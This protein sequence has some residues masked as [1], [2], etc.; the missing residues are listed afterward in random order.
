[1][2]RNFIFFYFL[3]FLL[4]SCNEKVNINAPYKDIYVVY[5]VLNPY[6]SAQY[7]RISKVFQTEEDAF[8]TAAENDFSLKGLKVI[9]TG[10]GKT[11]EA[12][13]EDSMPKTPQNGTFY[14]Y[15]TVY[16]LSANYLNGLVVG[17]R[18][19]LR[20]TDPQNADFQ[21]N[22]HTSIPQV[23]YLLSPRISNN[24]LTGD[25]CIAR[26]AFEDT[27]EIVFEGNPFY[28]ACPGKRYEVSLLWNYTEK[29]QPKQYSWRYSSLIEGSGEDQKGRAKIMPKSA[30]SPFFNQF[31]DTTKKYQ[32]VNEPSCAQSILELPTSLEIFITSLDTTL[33][34]Y[35]M[36]NDP[37]YP[38]FNTYRPEYTNIRGTKDAVGIFGSVSVAKSPVLLTRCG[39]YLLHVNNVPQQGISCK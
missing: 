33:S 34:D 35:L 26:L 12:I 1:M 17:K 39:E 19:D 13:E 31:E 29:N 5:G 27:L 8:K 10:E 11:W 37:A 30:F 2:L 16:K 22:A 23:P 28:K 6:D 25:Y 9:L 3:A 36:V 24:P 18:Y 21:L 14:P 15:S 32:Y 20:I 38:N 4:F 7:I